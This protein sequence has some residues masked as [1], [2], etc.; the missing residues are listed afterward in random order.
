MDADV[1]DV[2][3]AEAVDE[4]PKPW[5]FWAT[6]GLSLAVAAVFVLAQTAVFL[7][8]AVVAAG[9]NPAELTPQFIKNL[10]TDG[11]LLSLASWISLPFA[12]GLTVVLVKL[13]RRWVPRDYLAM[14]RVSG[15][16]LLVWLGF[17]GMLAASFQG[18]TSL[19]GCSSEGDFMIRIYETAGF[20]P[21]LWATLLVEAPLFEEVF[22]RGFMFRGIERSR[23]GGVGAVVLTSLAFTAIHVQYHAIELGWILAVG[24]L[25]GTARWKT[26]SVYVTMAMHALANLIS[27][28]EVHIYIVRGH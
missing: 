28:V 27:L 19:A 13:R 3:L 9:G 4:S 25:L 15:K 10:E 1:A 5:G 21:L 8:Y 24:I 2:V 17:V 18:I 20:L 12:L 22:F 7:V 23:L 16:T 11:L 14:R 26:G 6:L